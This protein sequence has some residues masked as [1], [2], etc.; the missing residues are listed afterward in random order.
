[1]KNYGLDRMKRR[2]QII[3][4]IVRAKY[5]AATNVNDA[6]RAKRSPGISV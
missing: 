1:M 3:Y 5:S 2:E 4:N 6:R